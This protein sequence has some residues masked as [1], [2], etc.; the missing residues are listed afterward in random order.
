MNWHKIL[1]DP[2]WLAVI[3]TTIFGLSAF[4]FAVRQDT[5]IRHWIADHRGAFFAFFSALILILLFL[6]QTDAGR[7]VRLSASSFVTKLQL[8]GR[9]V[10]T[11]THSGKEKNYI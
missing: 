4:F 8:H 6:T 9:L 5:Q 11:S 7:S 1:T 10:F 2:A 3:L